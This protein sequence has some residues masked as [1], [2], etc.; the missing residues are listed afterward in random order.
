MN[1]VLWTAGVTQEWSQRCQC[2][3]AGFLCVT[4]CLSGVAHCF[5]TPLWKCS[6]SS[7]CELMSLRR[8]Y[9][10]GFCKLWRGWEETTSRFL[11]WSGILEMAKVR[12]LILLLL[13][14]WAPSLSPQST[15]VIN[16]TWG[17]GSFGLVMEWD[18]TILRWIQESCR[19]GLALPVIVEPGGHKISPNVFSPR[20]Q[21]PLCGVCKRRYLN[22]V[23]PQHLVIFQDW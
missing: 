1:F 9:Q 10:R 13:G 11:L 18:D 22:L 20:S 21:T 8:P 3:F 14:P 19:S 6:T 17:A 5:R 15:Q 23:A 16:G 4:L 12:V 2:P 7:P